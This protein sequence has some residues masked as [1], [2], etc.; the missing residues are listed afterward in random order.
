MSHFAPQR[1]STR[2]ATFSA[3]LAAAA[4]ALTACGADADPSGPTSAPASAAGG[5]Q[6]PAGEATAASSVSAEDRVDPTQTTEVS[7]VT[8]RILLSHEDGLTLLDAE[9]GEVVREQD[10]PGFTRLSNAGNGKDVLVTTGNGWEVFSTGIQAKAHGDHVHNYESAPGMTGVTFPGEHPGHVVTHNG[11]TTLFADG[12]GAI[13]PST[14]PTWTRRP[15]TS[16]PS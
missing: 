16:C 15:R 14:R 13:G 7:A 3:T 8:P 11:K 5:A 1:R 6:S 12:T 4:I 10:V 9:S 2:T